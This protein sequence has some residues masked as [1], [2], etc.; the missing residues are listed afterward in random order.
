MPAG[1]P[2]RNPPVWGAICHPQRTAQIALGFD[3]LPELSIGDWCRLLCE[4][5]CGDRL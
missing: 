5:D 3:L 4:T 2:G 1:E